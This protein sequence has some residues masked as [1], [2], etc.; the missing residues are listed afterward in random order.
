M[1]FSTK[2]LNVS[3]LGG[4]VLAASP[5]WAEESS[6]VE[7]LID[8]TTYE[9]TTVGSVFVKNVHGA[10]SGDVENDALESW[11]HLRLKSREFIGDYWVFDS[12]I[13]AVV[14]SFR[15]AERGM[16]TSPGSRS[17][18]GKFVDIS[19]LSLSYLGDTAEYMIGKGDIK[20][21]FA[22]LYSP[23]DLYGRSN[24][25]NP[26]HAIEFGTW[27]ARGDFYFDQDRLT[28]IIIPLEESAPSVAPRSRWEGGSG[29][30]SFSSLDLG[31]AAGIT[32]EIK[33]DLRGGRPNE[34]GYLVKY[35]GVGEGMDYF[36][37][38]YVGPSPYPVLK[39]GSAATLLSNE[40]IKEK[41]QAWIGSAGAAFTEGGWK[42]YGETVLYQVPSGKDD[43]LLRGLA[44]AKYRETKFANSIGFDEISPVVEFS[45]ERRLAKQNHPEYVASS[46]S[47]RPNPRNIMASVEFK[48]DAEWAFGAAYNR[49]VRVN[50]EVRSAFVKYQP[51]DSLYFVLSGTDYRG[52]GESQYG[53][54]TRNDNIELLAKYKF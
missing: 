9:A 50:D 34:W 27:Q 4:A 45:Y 12:R 32:P 39:R 28:A 21:G 36:V 24:T 1:R 35:Q 19:Q 42:Y 15:G 8:N 38:G 37:S 40:F 11:N 41:P 53:I 22:E 10:E 2:L 23:S 29:D 30:S 25:A 54:W 20:V 14:S 18:R 44:G 16:F 48:V 51:Q 26:Q 7:R 5:A 33:D 17:G 46:E 47:A 13:D 3:I 31:L 6:F 49:N 52:T 43:D